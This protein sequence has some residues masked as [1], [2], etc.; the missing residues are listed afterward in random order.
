MLFQDKKKRSKM[1]KFFKSSKQIVPFRE[2]LKQ[3]IREFNNK[4]KKNGFCD[5]LI[6][7]N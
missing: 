2:N 1:V 7:A 3:R 5:T 6:F 4:K